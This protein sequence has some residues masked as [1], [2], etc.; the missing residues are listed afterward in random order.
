MLHHITISTFKPV[1]TLLPASSLVFLHPARFQMSRSS[2]QT[3]L[4]SR[5]IQQ[6]MQVMSG[7]RVV[8]QAG[9]SVMRQVHMIKIGARNRC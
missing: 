3:S 4:L 9:A 2:S 6:Y 5:E 8:R 1:I 7:A